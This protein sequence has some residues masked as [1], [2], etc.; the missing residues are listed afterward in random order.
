MKSSLLALSLSFLFF[1][2][3]TKPLLGRSDPL[4][5]L[6]GDKVEAGSA[7]YIVSIIR[8]AGGGGLTL[9]PNRNG[10]CPLDVTQH[11]SDLLRGYPMFFYPIN[12]SNENRGYVHESM[13][14]NIQFYA[15]I[16]SCNEPMVWKVDNYDEK[17]GAWFITTNGVV[18]NPG[19]QTLPNWFK[20]VKIG[21]G[22]N[23]Y[24]I[25]HCPSDV[26]ESTVHL[27]SD[28]GINYVENARRLALSSTQ[29][30]RLGFIKAQV[31][32]S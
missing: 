31:L 13:D 19:P 8:G 28:V 15:N 29:S 1:A 22:I 2:L 20:F 3:L 27:C 21:V 7:Y 5:D 10:S 4:L 23:S 25:V 12:Y 14:V 11:S 9:S 17:R 6:D 18:G 16:I 26:S 32:P 24:K 30:F